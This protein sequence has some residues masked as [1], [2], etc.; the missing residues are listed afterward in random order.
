M[1]FRKDILSALA[2]KIQS[3]DDA[4][5]S[6]WRYYHQFFAIN[7]RLEIK[8]V[9]GFGDGK[10]PYSP[11]TKHIHHLLQGR[12]RKMVPNNSFFQKTYNN[13]QANTLR[14]SSRF[15]LDT[16]RQV[17]TLTYLEAHNLISENNIALVI[18][19]GF[20]CMGSLLLQS[21]FA[22][23][24]IMVNL[25]KTL[26]VDVTHAMTLPELA[27]NK[28]MVLVNNESDLK[29][30]VQNDNSKMIFI[31]ALNCEILNVSE[32]DLVFNIA[33]MQ[34][35]DM[36]YINI[37]FGQMRKIA[38]KK[39]VYFYCCNRA[40]KI[41]PDKTLIEFS[42]YPWKDQD[43]HY[44]DELCPWHQDYYRLIPKF[45]FPYDGPIIHRFTKLSA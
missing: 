43:K 28:S 12:Y 3:A 10:K 9:T 16:L 31:E 17:L 14:N 41:F 33:S 23:K 34:E 5:S 38:Q 13:A 2:E 1:I 21:G 19:D 26:F 40:S 35:M 30:A 45:Y 15:S 6:H 11:F 20:A 39:S 36:K 18:G 27:K 24:V 22:K 8:K 25:T 42:A 4:A 32:A 44:F 37:Y 29:N 7:E